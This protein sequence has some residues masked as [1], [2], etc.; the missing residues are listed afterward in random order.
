MAVVVAGVAN[1]VLTP[2]NAES[3]LS[4]MLRGN[5]I[6]SHPFNHGSLG[7]HRCFGCECFRV[8]RVFPGPLL[9]CAAPCRGRRGGWP[10]KSA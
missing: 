2:E 10:Q 9:A 6:G 7:W 8:F 1:R 4:G 3:P 5:P